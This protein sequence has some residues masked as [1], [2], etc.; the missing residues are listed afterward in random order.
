MRVK[1]SRMK[2]FIDQSTKSLWCYNDEQYVLWH[3][4]NRKSSE[5]QTQTDLHDQWK[6]KVWSYRSRVGDKKSYK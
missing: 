4:L 6:I 5:R 1:T 3:E 2:E